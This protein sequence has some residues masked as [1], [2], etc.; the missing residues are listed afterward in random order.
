MIQNSLIIK[1]IG[2]LP[3]R[4]TKYKLKY[5]KTLLYKNYVKREN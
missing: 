1:E 3:E 4:H 2:V 5:S